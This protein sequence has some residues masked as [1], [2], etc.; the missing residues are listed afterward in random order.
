MP[1]G[2]PKKTVAAAQAA[3]LRDNLGSVLIFG[4]NPPVV[5]FSDG[6]IWP[7]A[8]QGLNLRV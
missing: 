7:S 8:L 6:H 5:N 2:R 1:A 4:G 3:D